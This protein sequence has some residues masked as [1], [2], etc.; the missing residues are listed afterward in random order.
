MFGNKR[1]QEKLRDHERRQSQERFER[2][3]RDGGEIYRR[4]AALKQMDR[5]RVPHETVLLFKDAK[6]QTALIRQS[7]ADRTHNHFDSGDQGGDLAT[8][9]AD[10]IAS[11]MREN[12]TDPQTVFQALSEQLPKVQFTVDWNDAIS[13]VSAMIREQ[14]IDGILEGLE[15]AGLMEDKGP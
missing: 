5:A 3:E 9:L 11:I 10:G 14:R 15:I 1:H 13:L 6:H 8:F 4:V 12:V 7:I 2:N